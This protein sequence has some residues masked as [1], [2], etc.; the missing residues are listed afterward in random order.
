MNERAA[1]PL[2]LT[3]AELKSVAGLRGPTDISMEA[4]REYIQPDGSRYEV[5]G[6]IALYRRDGGST[7][8]VVTPDGALHIVPVG[9]ST[10]IVCRNRDPR[11]P[12]LA[13]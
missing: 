6:P 5:A 11:V 7:H 2:K 3:F 13:F 1:E 8:R 12:V 9:P 4:S 10:V